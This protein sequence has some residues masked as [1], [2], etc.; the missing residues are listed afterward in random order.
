MT[1]FNRKSLAASVSL[2]ILWATLGTVFHSAEA[3]RKYYPEGF[4]PPIDEGSTAEKKPMPKPIPSE[5]ELHQQIIIKTVKIP[6]KHKDPLQECLDEQH[7]YEALRLVNSRLAHSPGNPQLMLIRGKILAERGEYAKAKSSFQTILTH[8][9]TT[10]DL[11][12][13]VLN[14]L[15]NAQLREAQQA[16]SLDSL[17]PY[18]Q[19]LSDAKASFHQALTLKPKDYEAIAGLVSIELTESDVESAKKILAP[20]LHG[21]PTNPYLQLAQTQI[22]LAEDRADEL[23]P[24]IFKVKHSVQPTISLDLLTAKAF[25]AVHRYDDAIIQLQQVLERVPEQPEAV[26]L[27]SKSYEAKNRPETAESVLLKAIAT[28]PEDSDSVHSLLKIYAQEGDS[29]RQILL[30]K[31]VLQQRPGDIGYTSAL[32]QVQQEEDQWEDAYNTGLDLISELNP[33]PTEASPEFDHFITL[34]SESAY[35]QGKRALDR[36]Q[37]LSLP[38]IHQVQAYLLSQLA[39]NPK[40]LEARLSLLMLDPMAILPELPTPLTLTAE[41]TM[42]RLKIAF[43][44]G[45][46][47]IHQALINRLLQDNTISE[48]SADDFL[49]SLKH[50]CD[51]DA[52]MRLGHQLALRFPGSKSIARLN[53]E[54]A[55]AQE[56]SEEKYK[57]LRMLPSS[58]PEA[59]WKGP[60]EEALLVSDNDWQLHAWIANSLMARKDYRLALIQQE[61]AARYALSKSDKSR[62]LKKA[63]K[64]EKHINH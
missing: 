48:D 61:L 38:A 24:I 59:Y 9:R 13:Q 18:Q 49:A 37:F 46:W 54:I 60:A 57:V 45:N 10:V 3:A 29:Q 44:Q 52:A 8:R 5:T 33:A 4:T 12:V 43:L 28:H 36:Q 62:W 16:K 20:A 27:L 6:S 25:Y 17:S 23:L 53:Q 39:R 2:V 31:S 26:K 21:A 30:L 14:A 63:R 7:Y 40:D 56:T 1:P 41:D 51:Y 50:L 64:T 11:K 47:Q 19:G 32:M 15:G 34:F 55:L 35:L 22:L 42:V 58:M